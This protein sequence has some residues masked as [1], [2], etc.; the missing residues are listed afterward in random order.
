MNTINLDRVPLFPEHAGLVE[1]ILL[2]PLAVLSRCVGISSDAKE[3]L[4][5]S[6]SS[7]RLCTPVQI[8]SWVGSCFFSASLTLSFSCEKSL[9]RSPVRPRSFTMA[10]C[11]RLE[12]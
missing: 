2:E 12:G 8:T 4:T 7:A 6:S 11:D 10:V 9:A 1:S 3:S 5:R